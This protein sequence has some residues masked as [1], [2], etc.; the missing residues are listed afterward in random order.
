MLDYAHLEA[1]LAVEREKSFEGAAKALGVTSSA[2]SQRIKLLE[3][4]IGAVTLNRQTPVTPTEVGSELCRHAEMVL[5]LEG[6]VM[7]RNRDELGYSEEGFRKI[8]IAVNDD[9][10]SSW[11]M[12]IL[13]ANS[14]NTNPY[15]LE[16][17]IA[18]QDYSIDQMKAGSALAAISIHK[19]PVQGFQSTYLGTHVYRATASPEFMARYFPNGVTVEALERAPSLRYSSQ[20]DLQI[21]WI[22]Q[23]LGAS[24]FPPS[25]TIPSSHGFV[26]A[27]LANVA[28]G[29]NPALMVDD[30]IAEGKLVELVPGQTL[31]KP[32]YWHCSKVIASPFKHFT[33]TVLE[34]AHKLLDQSNREP[35]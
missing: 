28:W 27:C 14:A 24:V 35:E 31:D 7:Q 22:D 2:I 8:K 1:L 4:R 16:I 30:L 23:V 29:M 26:S 10:L 5:M 34:E 11:F 33:A 32:L 25:H 18:D 17:S 20:D 13:E 12:G 6:E 3:E 19:N 21:Q 15:L 9:S